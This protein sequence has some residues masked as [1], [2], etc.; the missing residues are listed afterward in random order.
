MRK[1]RNALIYGIAAVAFIVV[2]KWLDENVGPA[3]FWVVLTAE[4]I[5]L[6]GLAVGAETERRRI[7][8]GQAVARSAQWPDRGVQILPAYRQA[9]GRYRVVH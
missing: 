1:L 6:A 3:W 5:F 8:G 9:A 4:L 2:A 7:S